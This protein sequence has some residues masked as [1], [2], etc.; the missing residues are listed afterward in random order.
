M[1]PNIDILTSKAGDIPFGIL[2]TR[3][4]L[5][6]KK[7]ENIKGF[8]LSAR[9]KFDARNFT[10]VPPFFF[11]AESDSIKKNKGNTDTVLIN[12]VN[13]L[14]K[15]DRETKD[16]SDFEEKASVSSIFVIQW[17]YLATTDKVKQ[18]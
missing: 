3:N 13:I 10:P 16:G 6:L 4:V 2:T 7:A 14:N 5:S 18:L 9:Q 8:N 11:K 17:L 1:V 12:S 15:F